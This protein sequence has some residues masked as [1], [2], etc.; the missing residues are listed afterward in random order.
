MAAE[1]GEDAAGLELFETKIRPVLIQHCYECHS[2]KSKRLRGGLRVDIRDGL[3]KGGESGDPCVV[4]GKPEE[5]TLLGALRHDDY[6]MPPAGKLS[7]AIIKDFEQWIRLGAPDPRDGLAESRKP[8]AVD[9]EAGRRLWAF[10]KP[11]KSD[12]PQLNGIW[13]DWAKT[14]IDHFIAAKLQAAN[15]EPSKDADRHTLLRRLTY[16]LTGLPPTPEAIRRFVADEAPDALE[17]EVDRLL[18]SKAFAERWARHWL[19][20]ARFAESSGGGRSLMFPHAWRYRDYVI[21]S[22]QQDK[23]FN[24]FLT[25]QIA[26]DLM[27]GDRPEQRDDQLIGLGDPVLGAINY[28]LQDKQ[29]LEMEV[30]DEQLEA[31]GRGFMGMTL[32]CARCHDH[33]FDPISTR[34]YYSLAGIFSSTRAITPGNVSGYVTRELGP[35]EAQERLQTHTRLLAEANKQLKRRQAERDKLARRLTT[36]DVNSRSAGLIVDDKQA[37]LVGQWKSSTF[38]DQRYGD[39]YIHD[40]QMGKGHWSAAFNFQLPSAGRYEVWVAYNHQASRALRVPIAIHHAGGV[41]KTLL[42][43]Q[44]PP[45]D[46]PFQSVGDFQFG[47]EAAGCHFQRRDRWLLCHC[48]CR[49]AA[50]CSGLQAEDGRCVS[51]GEGKGRCGAEGG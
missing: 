6:E 35:P 3:R 40:A 19:D 25:E 1:G 47:R 13:K 48:G 30:I 44:L 28:E 32:A 8:H 16:D 49:G 12:V 39:Q 15:L 46:A 7:D 51:R 31:I 36:K 4:P 43:Q 2:A 23:P 11:Q 42:N 34:D 20:V 17:R 27:P 33:K 22:F 5:G 24:R 50:A 37:K 21:R 26:G 10:R 41:A 9:L 18:G 45:A 14:D 29:L 38:S